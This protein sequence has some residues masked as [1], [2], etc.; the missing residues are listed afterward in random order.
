MYVCICIQYEKYMYTYISWQLYAT[1]MSK[2][3]S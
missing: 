1:I 2:K 3:L